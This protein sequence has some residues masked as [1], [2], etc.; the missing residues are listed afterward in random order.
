MGTP[1]AAASQGGATE[2]IIK[3]RGA[4]LSTVKM[5]RF[6]FWQCLWVALSL[7]W[8][9]VGQHLGAGGLPGQRTPRTGA[10][11]PPYEGAGQG[12]WAR[13]AGFSLPFQ[14]QQEQTYQ[15]EQIQK[16]LQQ[17]FYAPQM[18][19]GQTYWVPRQQ[20]QQMYTE[21]R[22]QQIYAQQLQQ[23]QIYAQQQQQ[24][25]EIGYTQAVELT[26]DQLRAQQRALMQKYLSSAGN[27]VLTSTVQ[28]K[29]LTG[30]GQ[31]LYRF[32]TVDGSLAQ[33][34]LQAAV[35]LP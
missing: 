27:E 22:Q 31:N 30:A 26:T 14:Q 34:E 23:Q 16:T 21:Q 2:Q 3:R 11:W 29:L 7:P 32:S 24:L 6:W 28:P 5:P 4:I 13:Q 9:V 35:A 18:V 15:P 17:Q 33:V 25:P 12:Y 19:S 20:Q 1:V 8:A 10:V